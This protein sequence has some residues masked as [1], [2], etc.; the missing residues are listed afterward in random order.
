MFSVL[1]YVNGYFE[2]KMSYLVVAFAIPFRE[3]SSCIAVVILRRKE[4]DLYFDD[5]IIS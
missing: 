2:F 1:F 4:F 3:S 5:F